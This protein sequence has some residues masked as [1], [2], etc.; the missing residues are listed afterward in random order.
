MASSPAPP[1][2]PLPDSTGRPLST[3]ERTWLVADR[4]APP[5]VNQLVLEGEGWPVPAAGWPRLLLEL[6]RAVPGCRLRLRG[7][8]GGCRWVADGP[9][10]A[11]QEVDGSCWDG[12]GPAGA[13]WLRAPL[14]PEQGPTCELLLVRPGAPPT[15]PASAR[16][17]GSKPPVPRLVLRTHHAVTDG[18]GTLLLARALFALLRQEQPEPATAGLPTDEGL[19][20]MAPLPAA[21]WQPPPEQ[22][23]SPVG[24]ATPDLAAGLR[25]A[26][27]SVPG[28]FSALL[29][30]VLLLLARHAGAGPD[31]PVLVSV[32]VDLRPHRP[33]LHSTANLTGFHHVPL[34]E[35]VTAPDPRAAIQGALAA[36]RAAGAELAHLRFLASQ[37]GLRWTPLGVLA[38][39]AS[40]LAR[41]ALARDRFGA[42]AAVSN[43]G[44]LDLTPLQGGGF[45]AR[46]AFFIP[47]GNPAVPL[48]L[49]LTGG[50][51]GLELCG[52]MP[53]SLAGEGRLTG[54]LAALAG[55]LQDP[56]AA[57]PLG[58]Y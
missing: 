40:R 4:V 33:G 26:R 2:R 34:H 55:G 18:Q 58:R 31:R 7:A 14:S 10:P 16:G 20:T 43:L 56:A 9:L 50:P 25:W 36:Q 28:R 19:A 45:V 30:Q 35:L 6:A 12:Q 48:F 13:P 5:F 49:T 1:S 11:V 22:S 53:D 23:V 52:T 46:R 3:L 27:Q 54:L 8:L 29:P 42:S 24:P 44:R 39:G 15:A 41:Q 51:A 21:S 38:A 37:P 17:A 47:P 32:P 57:A